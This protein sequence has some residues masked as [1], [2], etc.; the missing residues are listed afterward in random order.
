MLKWGAFI[1]CV[2]QVILNYGIFLEFNDELS[3]DDLSEFTESFEREVVCADPKKEQQK[4]LME[5]LPLELAAFG[6]F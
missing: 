6:T 4:Q 5:P 2:S 3:N 1:E